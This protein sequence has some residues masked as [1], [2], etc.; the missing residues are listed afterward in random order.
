MKAELL[1]P[2]EM[3][4]THPEYVPGE[5]TWLQVGAII[6]N[7]QAFMLVRMGCAKPADD[8]CEKAAQMTPTAMEKAKAAY[9]RLQ[10]GIAPE[11]FEAFDAGEISGYDP[12]TGEPIPGPNAIDEED[13]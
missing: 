11:D 5:K 7:P 10:K 4:P 8:E 9:E 2:M 13:D 3:G 1:R 12:E 6:E